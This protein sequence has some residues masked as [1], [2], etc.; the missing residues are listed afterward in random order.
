MSVMKDMKEKVRPLR[1]GSARARPDIAITDAGSLQDDQKGGAFIM[2]DQEK[3]FDS[4]AWPSLHAVVAALGFR[5]Q[6]PTLD[7]PPI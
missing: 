7:H 5:P 4:C 6:S 2:L 1:V 3:A